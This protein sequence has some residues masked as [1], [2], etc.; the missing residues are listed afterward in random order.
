MIVF[1]RPCHINNPGSG[2]ANDNEKGFENDIRT[3]RS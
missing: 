1:D 2:K 3:R